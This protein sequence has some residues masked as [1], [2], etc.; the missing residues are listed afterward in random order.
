[1]R[2][3]P[4]DALQTD[5]PNTVESSPNPILVSALV[6]FFSYSS[7]HISLALVSQIDMSR[8]ISRV[9]AMKDSCKNYTAVPTYPSSNRLIHLT[10]NVSKQPFDEV[11]G[12]IISAFRVILM[13]APVTV[14]H[15]VQSK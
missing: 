8:V 5:T 10:N 11:R 9:E 15:Q 3:I 4:L 7:P 12:I 13:K 14:S 1:M 2:W 6:I